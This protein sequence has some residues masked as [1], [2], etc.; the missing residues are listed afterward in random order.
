M[1]Y[2]DGYIDSLSSEATIEND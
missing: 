1:A 2:G